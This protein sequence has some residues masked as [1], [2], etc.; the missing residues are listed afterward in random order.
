MIWSLYRF[1]VVERVDVLFCPG[2]TYTIVCVM[3][4]L[5]LGERCPPVLVKISND[6][7]RQDLPRLIGWLYRLWLEFQGF[8][9]DHFVA[10]AEPMLP[11]MIDKLGI[12]AEKA[13][14][15][16]DPALGADERI[17]LGANRVQRRNGACRFLSVGRLVAQKNHA[18]LIEAFALHAWPE[19]RLVIAGEGPERRALEYVIHRR[20]LEG[21]V[22]LAGHCND[23]ASLYGQADVFVLS[24]AYEGVPAVIVEA[25]AAG[26]PVAATD[27][28]ASMNWLLHDG[29]FG[30]AVPP[31]DANALGIAMNAARLLAPSRQDMADFAARFSVEHAAGAYLEA[32]EPLCAMRSDKQYQRMCQQM[33]DFQGH[34]V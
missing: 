24:S 10:L 21:R 2:N 12:A 18:L 34:G 9:L 28:C 13:T 20:G 17:R 4:R 16:T 22:R 11:Q 32:M 31:N 14:V 1:L 3:M 8:F 5:L 29:Q 6:L 19:D 15:I 27:C 30:I 33:R 7:E 26:L 25:L 23:V